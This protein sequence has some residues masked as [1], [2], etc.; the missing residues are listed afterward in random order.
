MISSA[1]GVAREG[2]AGAWR[3]ESAPWYCLC[4]E[5][6][7]NQPGHR[8]DAGPAGGRAGLL[9]DQGAHLLAAV[10]KRNFEGRIGL[11]R[12]SARVAQIGA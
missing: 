8:Q 3:W 12:G 5:R 1:A 7:G 10:A 9:A 2:T 6:T 4:T 11:G